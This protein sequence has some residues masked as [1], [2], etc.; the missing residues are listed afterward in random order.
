MSEHVY[1]TLEPV[2]DSRSRVLI[3][4]SIPSPRSRELGFYYA[5]PQNRFWKTL[6]AVFGAP[7]FRSTEEKRGFCLERGIALWD[8]IAEC[9]IAGASDASIRRAVPNDISLITKTC[10]IKKIFTTGR[11]AHDLLYKLC[12]IESVCLPSPS[13]A[14][15]AVSEAQLTEKYSA[16]AEAL[17]NL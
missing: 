10:D 6:A 1:H 8:V 14:N 3:L 9:D 13:A 2:F 4:G 11:L 15:C 7:P 16:I 17:K 12:G 5:H